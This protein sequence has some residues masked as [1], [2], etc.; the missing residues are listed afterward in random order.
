MCSRLREVDK[1]K[2]D[3]F[4]LMS[5]ELRTPLTSI[6]EGTNLFLEGRAGQVTAD[7]KK[8]LTIIAEESNRLITLAGSVLELSRLEAGTVSY[9]FSPE[10]LAPLIQTVLRETAPLAESKKIRIDCNIGELP[11]LLLDSERMLQA[12]RNI[13]GN[14]LKF[15]PPAGRISISARWIN[16]CVIVSISDT[17]PGIPREYATAIFEKFHQVPGAGRLNGTGLGLAIVK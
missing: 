4:A 3:F 13:I 5:H 16:D 14:A 9:H 15:T 17:G 2:S 8:L 12:V 11:R 10:D 7:Q 1:M 6:K